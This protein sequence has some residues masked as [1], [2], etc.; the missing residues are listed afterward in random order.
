M[1]N[2]S[3]LL[4]LVSAV[5]V[6]I[7]AVGCGSDSM[8]GPSGVG[9]EA[10]ARASV[11]TLAASSLKATGAASA[12][13]GQELELVGY[14]KSLKAPSLVVAGKTVV[15]SRATEITRNKVRVSLASIRVG[16]HVKVEGLVRADGKVQAREVKVGYKGG[17][18]NTDPN[19]HPGTGN[20]DGPNHD[21]GDDHGGNGNDDGPNHNNGDDNGGNGNDD[22]GNDGAGHN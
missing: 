3:R 9:S 16:E 13:L 22:N 10:G 17:T 19:D 20:D 21:N 2:T 4:T 6:S 12:T 15:T 11:T 5:A 14:V 18:T 7:A 8:S 1:R